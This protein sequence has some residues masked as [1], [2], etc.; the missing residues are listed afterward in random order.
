ME[1]LRQSIDI[2]AHEPERSMLPNTPQTFDEKAIDQIADELMTL[3]SPAPIDI[4]EL[5]RQ[6]GSQAHIVQAA[7][8]ELE[9]SGLIFR[10]GAK[11][12]RLVS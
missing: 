5:I 7:I 1:A 9:L 8:V 3:L 10:D 6:T 12:S 11:V 4:D 2:A